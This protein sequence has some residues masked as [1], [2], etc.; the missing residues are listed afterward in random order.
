MAEGIDLDRYR[1]IGDFTY[2][3]SHIFI[4]SNF[5]FTFGQIGDLCSVLVY[6]ITHCM[7][8]LLLYYKNS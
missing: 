5:T 1:I 2:F 3:F 6:I 8:K 4:F 7:F